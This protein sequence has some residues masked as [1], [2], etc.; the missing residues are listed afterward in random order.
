[1]LRQ[2]L[3]L[4]PAD[5]EILG[6]LVALEQRLGHDEDADAL[7]TR[8]RQVQQDDVQYRDLIEPE[9]A[10]KDFEELAR[11]AERLGRRFEA[12][13]WTTLALERK[14]GDR[15]LLGRLQGLEAGR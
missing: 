9:D 4:G 12:L 6:R 5:P 10:T 13:G 2:I 14:P 8:L 15:E 3:D 11:L 7:R 1:M